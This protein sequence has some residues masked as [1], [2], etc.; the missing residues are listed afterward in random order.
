M[1]DT[2]GFLGVIEEDPGTV[3]D[4]EVLLALGPS[5]VDTGRGLG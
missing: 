5:A 1:S 2:H 3:L 4:A